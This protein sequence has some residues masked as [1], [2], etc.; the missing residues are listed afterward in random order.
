MQCLANERQSVNL[1]RL[2]YFVAVAE[3][4][5]YARAARR[6]RI[7]GPSLSQQIK[8]LEGEL[9][10]QLFERNRHSVTLTPIGSALL[11]QARALLTHADE[12]SRRVRDLGCTQ[13]I[14]LGLVDRCRPEWIERLSRVASINVDSW[15]MPSHA[16]A[17]RVAAG[18]LDLAICHVDRADLQALGLAAHLVEV[19]PLYAIGAASDIAPTRASSTAV[20][21]DADTSSWK[22]WNSF[23]EEFARATEATIVN[24]EDG[25]LTGRAFLHHARR[26]RRPTLKAPKGAFDSLP[27]DMVKS[28]IVDPVPIWTWSLVR[29]RADERPAVRAAVEALSRGVM[30]PETRSGRYWLPAGDP[31]TQVAAVAATS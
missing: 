22:S 9:K 11:P 30:A 14:R 6:L 15:V 16:Q 28:R 25:G 31:H 8:L 19:D 12:L 26:A 10:A 23:A 21:V 18:N 20:L 1:R 29:R 5:S 2:G 24:I 7:A 13:T 3:E 27:K 17:A 4:L